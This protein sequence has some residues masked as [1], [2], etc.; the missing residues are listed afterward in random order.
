MVWKLP[1]YPKLIESMAYLVL[2]D[3]YILNHIH[4]AQSSQAKSQVCF[5]LPNHQQHV[6]SAWHTPESFSEPRF[7]STRFVSSADSP[8]GKKL[9]NVNVGGRTVTHRSPAVSALV[10]PTSLVLVWKDLASAPLPVVCHTA[11]FNV[12]A[13]VRRDSFLMHAVKAVLSCSAA[14]VP[15]WQRKQNAVKLLS[16]GLNWWAV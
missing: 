10:D 12:S 15:Q 11:L 7:L 2:G 16:E 6:S 1:R 8:A 9:L 14:A 5:L 3:V 13:L 4:V